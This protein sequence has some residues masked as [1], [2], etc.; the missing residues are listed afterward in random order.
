MAVHHL[1]DAS[2]TF[3]YQQSGNLFNHIPDSREWP[4]YQLLKAYVVNLFRLL[5]QL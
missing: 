2:I 5:K 4:M 1:G 3:E